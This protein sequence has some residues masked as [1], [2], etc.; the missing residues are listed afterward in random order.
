VTNRD[1]DEPA[2]RGAVVHGRG[3]AVVLLAVSTVAACAGT[4]SPSSAESTVP[5]Q[6]VVLQGTYRAADG[7]EL[8]EV[9]FLA[10]Q[11]YALRTSACEASS[12]VELGEYAIDSARKTVVLTS[13]T[14]GRR[15][16]S[17]GVPVLPAPAA[18]TLSAH[19]GPQALTGGAPALLAS[20]ESSLRDF[21]QGPEWLGEDLISH[22]QELIRVRCGGEGESPL[23]SLS[24]PCGISG[25][26]RTPDGAGA[27]G[28]WVTLFCAN[29][30]EVVDM[31]QYP[32]AV[33]G[34]YSVQRI[35]CE[36]CTFRVDTS[37]WS[38]PG[39]VGALDDNTGYEQRPL[40]ESEIAIQNHTTADAVV[41][42]VGPCAGLGSGLVCS[43][44][45]R[46]E[47]QGELQT[48]AVL[49]RGTKCGTACR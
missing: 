38:F 8:A 47:C 13:S 15:T 27:A 17:I 14:G 35:G 42:L 41:D 34:T 23:S 12:C 18:P 29:D 37:Q 10:D 46:V 19:V 43:N 16:L 39:G 20:V 28:T 22:G 4:S 21:K 44:G 32:V 40:Y 25:T 7:G 3:V 48:S 2:T 36:R 24:R 6:E 9:A 45:A 49:C 5:E 31:C 1:G 11:R 30:G 26:I 33:D